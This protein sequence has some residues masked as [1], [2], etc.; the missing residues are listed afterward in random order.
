MLAFDACGWRLGYGGG[1][2]DRTVAGLRAG[3]NGV[4]V[5]GI[6]YDGQKLDKIPVGPYDMSLDAVLSPAGMFDFERGHQV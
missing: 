3:N 5:I 6:A 2:Y 1:F 4:K